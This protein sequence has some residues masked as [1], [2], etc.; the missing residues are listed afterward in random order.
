V[1]GKPGGTESCPANLLVNSGVVAEDGVDPILPNCRI[2][3]CGGDAL[4]T[5]IVHDGEDAPGD[6]GGT[7]PM[8]DDCRTL[9]PKLWES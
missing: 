7:K 2:N 4:V 8:V 6:G 5:Y 1:V 3:S 9:L